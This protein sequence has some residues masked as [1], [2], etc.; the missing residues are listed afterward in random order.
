MGKRLLGDAG[1]AVSADG[2]TDPSAVV[3]PDVSPPD[4]VAPDTPAPE[5]TAT[6]APP[7][8]LPCQA[9]KPLADQ[10]LLLKARAREVHFASDRSY[11]ILRVR[12]DTDA[13]ANV[14]DRLVRIE[15]PSG[16][17]TTITDSAYY[18]EALGPNGALLVHDYLG[19]AHDL[20]IYD[21][22]S[23]RHIATGACQVRIAPDGGRLYV[24]A[25]CVDEQYGYLDVIDVATGGSSV[26][27]EDVVAGPVAIAP[28]GHWIA[29]VT[30]DPSGDASANVLHLLPTGGQPYALASAPGAH[31]PW[32][33]SDDLLVFTGGSCPSAPVPGCGI[34]GHRV[35]TGDTSYLIE[36]AP[37]PAFPGYQISADQTL[38]L[39]SEPA[40]ADG[41][42]AAW[43]YSVSLDGLERHLL[44]TN[45]YMFWVSSMMLRPFAFDGLGQQVL[46]VSAGSPFGVF[47][48]DPLGRSPRKLADNATFQP[49]AGSSTAI[50]IEQTP[51][52]RQRLR[53]TELDSGRDRLSLNSNGGFWSV[54]PVRGDQ[55][56]LVPEHMPAGVTYL[57]YLSPS[58]PGSIQIAEWMDSQ[59][60]M[61]DSPYAEPG[62]FYPVDPTGCFIIVDTDLPPG[63]GT[64]LV[65]LPE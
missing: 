47:V 21:H 59:L 53:L 30:R 54:T 36:P 22:P 49:V 23:L 38:M 48:V 44:A 5:A 62:R 61:Q 43:L 57:R 25:G 65:L 40:F 31:A 33:V 12:G 28:S 11:V 10:E 16:K 46:Y 6:D 9:L 14:P 42:S 56:L 29:F 32:F 45:V 37:A 50:L 26:I 27:A 4:L 34:R 39:V 52:G 35:G 20:T 3:L 24:L 17:L 18:A 8:L 64:R 2:P 1:E 19:G 55:A 58:Y 41:G 60:T 15:L 63:P 51:E 13:S 7:A